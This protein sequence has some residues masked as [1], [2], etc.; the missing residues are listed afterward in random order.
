MSNNI[1]ILCLGDVVAGVGRT[2]I[3]D[4]LPIIKKD[5][6]IDFTIVNAE[7]ACGGLGLDMKHA[8]ELR[9]CGIDVITLGDH[10]FA[11]KDIIPLLD[12]NP[13]WLIRP[14]N[15]PL[16]APGRGVTTKKTSNGIEVNVVNLLGRVF[17]DGMWNCPFENSD[18]AIASLSQDSLTVF[19]FHCEATSE[20]IAFGRYVDGRAS[21]VFG[22]H[23]HVQT[24]DETILSNGTGYITDIGMCGS[25]SGVI[26]MDE[27]V[28]LFRFTTG[29][30][31]FYEAA[32][33]PGVLHG[34]ICEIDPLTRK[35]VRICRLK[36]PSQH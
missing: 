1:K 14:N 32:K 18:K 19:D 13:D 33:G 34:I 3:R 8:Y 30:P 27:S 7:N 24:A 31:K 6:A 28:A 2:A 17:M 11:K 4:Y 26:G 25:D 15:Y 16:G 35:A 29:R 9:D 5:N 23:T 10:S 20:K 36:Y 22:T 21:L 12:Q